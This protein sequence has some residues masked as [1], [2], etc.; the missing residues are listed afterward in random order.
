MHRSF[1]NVLMVSTNI[2]I[3]IINITL[4]LNKSIFYSDLK[5]HD[6]KSISTFG[7]WNLNFFFCWVHGFEKIRSVLHLYEQAE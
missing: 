2:Q 7:S 4:L 5:T 3:F 6:G 1:L